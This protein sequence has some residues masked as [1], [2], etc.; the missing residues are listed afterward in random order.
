MTCL[1]LRGELDRAHTSGQQGIEK[2]RIDS[3]KWI[4]N[5]YDNFVR[6]TWQIK[7]KVRGNNYFFHISMIKIINE[8]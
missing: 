6:N 1:I 5:K 8:D 4:K 2:K 3:M 7:M